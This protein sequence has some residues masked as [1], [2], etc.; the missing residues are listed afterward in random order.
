MWNNIVYDKGGLALHS[1]LKVIPT[2]H[3]DK[4]FMILGLSGTGKTTTTFTTQNGSKPIQDDFVG[5]MPGGHAYGTENGCFA[6]TFGWM[7]TSNPRSTAR[8]PSPRA[9]LENVYMDECGHGRLLQRELHEERARRV[10]DEGPAGLR[11]RAERG[12]RRLPADPQPQREHHPGRRQAEPGAGRRVLHARGDHRH[13]PPAA[14][15]RR[16]S[17]FGCPA[18]TRSSRSPTASR[19]TA[20]WS[21]WPSHPIETYLL[22]TG[23]VGGKDGDDRSKKVKIPHTSACV[24]GIAER[25]DHVGRRP[26]LRLPDRLGRARL[27]RRRAAA[28]SPPL[29]APGAHRRVRRRSWSA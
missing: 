11:G 28:A 14:P 26:G 16:A 13:R 10:R 8:S 4:V 15:P 12:R 20:C 25:L 7:P 19:A 24:K 3:G 23:R 1:G 5:L 22:N 6:K 9:Y 18:P 2:A 21:C 29:R 27:R 17:S